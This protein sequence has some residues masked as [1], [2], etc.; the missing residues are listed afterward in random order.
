MTSARLIPQELLDRLQYRFV[1]ERD[2]DAVL[3]G[4]IDRTTACF[5][6]EKMGV[7]TD[8]MVYEGWALHE[9]RDEWLFL[10]HRVMTGDKPRYSPPGTPD[11]HMYNAYLVVEPRTKPSESR[12]IL[13]DNVNVKIDGPTPVVDVIDRGFN[14]DFIETQGVVITEPKAD[15]G[16][17][18]VCFDPAVELHGGEKIETKPVDIYLGTMKNP[19]DSLVMDVLMSSGLMMSVAVD[20]IQ[21]MVAAAKMRDHV[22]RFDLQEPS[23]GIYRPYG[24]LGASPGYITVIPQRGL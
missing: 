8:L 12:T 21:D 6:Q 17:T 2:G 16:N 18:Y 24:E 5:I 11:R 19:S 3:D 22:Y 20:T 9:H 23:H 13:V 14:H 7:D 10:G 15:G 4:T 1:V